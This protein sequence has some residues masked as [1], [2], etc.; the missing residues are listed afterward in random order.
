MKHNRKDSVIDGCMNFDMS[1]KIIYVA[2]EY[3]N[4]SQ[5]TSK[6]QPSIVF[7]FILIFL[8]VHF[9]IFTLVASP[10]RFSLA[11]HWRVK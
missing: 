8:S 6:I 1:N 5:M 3:D 9:G 11:D 2:E 7:L 10:A 4:K